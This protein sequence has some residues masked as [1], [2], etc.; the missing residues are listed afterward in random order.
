MR[1][2][3]WARGFDALPAPT[4][5]P[6]FSFLLLLSSLSCVV[7]RPSVHHHPHRLATLDGRLVDRVADG[8]GFVAVVDRGVRFYVVLDTLHE[9]GDLRHEGVMRDVA[10]V[11]LDRREGPIAQRT[12]VVLRREDLIVADR[13]LSAEELAV[14]DIRR[15][16]VEDGR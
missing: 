9:V 1:W 14:E 7:R 10:V 5:S 3:G 16:G 4:A 15:I 2:R 11:R 13:P 6:R 8:H 12:R